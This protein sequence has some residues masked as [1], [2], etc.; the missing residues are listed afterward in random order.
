MKRFHY[1][2]IFR[3]EPEGGFTVSV[4]SLPG[5]ISYGKDL[6]EARKNILDAIDGY[7]A[8]LIKH[9]EVIPND[10]INFISSLDF[11]TQYTKK[12][13]YA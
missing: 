8:S 3:P 10:D 7:V 5:C 6:E 4:P 9:N 2:I 1:N 13:T 11:K 12:T